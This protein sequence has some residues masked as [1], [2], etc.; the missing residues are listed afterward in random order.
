ME[1]FDDKPVTVNKSEMGPVRYTNLSGGEY[2]YQMSVID[3]RTH[4]AKNTVGFKIIKQRSFYEHWA[5]FVLCGAFV[6][7]M[8][9][10]IVWLIIR[11]KNEKLRKQE[12][13][14]KKIQRLFEQTATALVNAIDAKDKYTHGHSS[15]VAEYSRKLAEMLGKDEQECN[16]VYYAGLLHDV[17]KIGVP[18][19]I[20]NKDGRLTDE[21]F[22]KIK[23]HPDMGAQILQSIDEYPFLSLGAR[24]HHERYDGKGYPQK[25]KGTDIPEF[26]RIISVADSYDAMTSK[27]SYRD[28]I[29]QQKVREEF[30]KGMGSQFDPEYARLMLHLID[31]DTEYTMKE[32]EVI[33]EFSGRSELVIDGFKSTVSDGIPI[34]PQMITIRFKISPK[35]G[36]GTPPVPTLVLFD[37]FDGRVH[38]DE[39]EIRDLLYF[40]YA[41]IRLDGKTVVK[42]ARKIVTDQR[43]KGSEDI[44]SPGHYTIEAVKVK[45][46]V[47]IKIYSSG[48]A[49]EVTAALPHS[50][51]F[52]Y[53]GL[54]GENCRISDVK[55][56]KAESVTPADKIKRI[57][58]EI[59]YI[60][61]PAGDIPNVQI[62]GYRTAAS[63]GIPVKDGMK[64]KFHAKS[65]PTARL[66]WHCPY[67]DIFTSD[68]GKVNGV[69]Y[70]DRS[71]MRIDGECWQ[72]DDAGKAELV[73]N[74]N[75]DFTGWD[76]WKKLNKDGL[77]CT[78]T[79]EKQGNTVTVFTENGGILIRVK[80]E[81][82][83]AEGKTIYAALTGDQCAI[84]NIRI[85]NKD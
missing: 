61:V 69:N 43:A 34:T 52:A 3:G 62:D 8:M 54:T 45:D 7:L 65:L 11:K 30:V 84:T 37:S 38:S 20:I 66:V 81:L 39:K 79:F 10:F 48:S 35:T 78:V 47:Q 73:V 59:S 76:N 68:D 29:P 13:E 71:F 63:E 85:I 40:E 75:D 18:E 67:I 49:I 15:R 9:V 64:L 27:R 24:Y 16:E 41:E 31:L 46:H 56:D 2:E 23:Q 5:F 72:N 26:A 32:R 58:E 53:I 50:S 14:Q 12:E 74:K 83:D 19:N 80:T 60:D 21:E 55:I 17:G 57:A 1:G 82:F 25:L 77:E 44:K 4:N 22:E 51:R 6:L 42:G 28:P 70:I 33:K 36:S